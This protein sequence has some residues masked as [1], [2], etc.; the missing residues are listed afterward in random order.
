VVP[1][2]VV[3]SR[4]K[5]LNEFARANNVLQDAFL[6]CCPKGRSS[7]GTR[8]SR[9][10]TSSA[11]PTTIPQSWRRTDLSWPI[12]DRFDALV[13]IPTLS[14]LKRVSLTLSKYQGKHLKDLRGSYSNVLTSEEMQSVWDDVEKV[15]VPS[16]SRS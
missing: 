3:T 6:G 1:R 7:T 10:P 5:W 16:R 8:N 13:E 11:L 2:R 9:A 14:L 4:L 15:T 12:A